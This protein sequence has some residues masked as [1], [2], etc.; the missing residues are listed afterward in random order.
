MYLLSICPSFVA[1]SLF[2]AFT[3]SQQIA[4]FSQKFSFLCRSNISP[5][6]MNICKHSRCIISNNESRKQFHRF[7]LLMWHSSQMINKMEWNASWVFICIWC[8]IACQVKAKCK[9]TVLNMKLYNNKSHFSGCHKKKLVATVIL[10]IWMKQWNKG[11]KHKHQI[12]RAL[13]CDVN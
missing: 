1:I 6:T 13:K 2:F 11:A 12:A 7:A 4:R 3:H 10:I 9:I 8:V 5:F